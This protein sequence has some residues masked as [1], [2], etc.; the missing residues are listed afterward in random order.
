MRCLLL[1]YR[2]QA[3]DPVSLV[4]SAAANTVV[5]THIVTDTVWTLAGSPYEVTTDI[6]VLPGAEL[7]VEPGVEVRFA[8]QAM[9]DVRGKIRATGTITD[10]ILFTGSTQTPGWW[11]G[12]HVS[13]ITGAPNV[14]SVF[15][16]VTIEYGGFIYA[17]LYFFSAEA[18]VDHSILRHSLKDGLYGLASTG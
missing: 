4:N 16:H 17:N 3:S 5:S 12:I 9:L 10:P 7:T 1:E 2:A 15:D 14:G 13:G 6:Q 8:Q 18:K 11:D